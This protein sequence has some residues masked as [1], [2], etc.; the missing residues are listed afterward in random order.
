MNRPRVS[1]A[2]SLEFFQ[3]WRESQCDWVTYCGGWLLYDGG[4]FVSR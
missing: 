4:L 3:A 2:M 1:T